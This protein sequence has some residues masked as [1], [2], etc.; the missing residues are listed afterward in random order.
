[1]VVVA[2][3]AVSV[4]AAVVVEV[5]KAVT[6]KEGIVVVVAVVVVMVMV[7]GTCGDAASQLYFFCTVKD[8]DNPW[9]WR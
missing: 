6:V 1:M 4:G 5:A 9:V 3:D 7:S 2:V 8:R